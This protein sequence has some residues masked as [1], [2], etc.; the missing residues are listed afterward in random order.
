M[1]GQEKYDWILSGLTGLEPAASA[2]TGRCSDQLNYNPKVYSIGRKSWVSLPHQRLMDLL[3]SIP[4]DF[5]ALL[6][7][8][9]SLSLFHWKSIRQTEH[10]EFH[11]SAQIL[12]ASETNMEVSLFVEDL[13][14]WLYSLIWNYEHL[15]RS[16]E[17]ARALFID[18][19]VSSLRLSRTPLQS[20][21]YEPYGSYYDSL[22]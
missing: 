12:C 15:A 4:F 2:L 5:L 6:I 7:N 10:K 22:P 17:F 8:S 1:V 14:F 21:F 9:N 18:F 20:I 11:Q 16:K 19:F 3:I 13:C